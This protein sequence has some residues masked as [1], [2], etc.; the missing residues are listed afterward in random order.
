MSVDMAKSKKRLQPKTFIVTGSIA[1]VSVISLFV[2]YGLGFQQGKTLNPDMYDATV[3]GK[4]VCLSHRNT[5]G[6]QTL[7]CAIGI[8]T[9]DGKHYSIS[10]TR[11]DISISSLAGS[12]KRVRISGSLK[13]ASD[14]KYV[15]DGILTVEQSETLE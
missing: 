6:P 8:E 14:S 15:S 13:E 9:D 7:E 1:I 12:E 5:N 11:S 4:I 3:E 10:D 2:G